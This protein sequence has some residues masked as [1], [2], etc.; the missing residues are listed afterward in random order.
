MLNVH[1]LELFYYVARAGGITASLRQIP[2]GIQQPA[3]SLQMSQ[4]EDAVGTQLFRR[5]PF[6]LTP[7]GREIYEFVTP[8]F[9]GLA[10]LA[11]R[12]QGQATQHLRLAASGAVMRE[13]FP[14]LLRELVRRIPGLRLS[15]RDTGPSGAARL[16]R[17][18]E[19]DLALG[20]HDAKQAAGLR[21]ELLAKLPM[22]L[23]V[24][25][26]S[27]FTNASRVL[28]EAATGNVP[29]ISSPAPDDLLSRFQAELKKR[30]I[31]WDVR[32]EA[33]ALDLVEAYVA[34]GFGVGLSLMIPG[35]ALAANIRVLKLAGFPIV[36]YGA[37]WNERLSSPA[38]HCLE[39]MRTRAKALEAG[40]YE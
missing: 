35:R 6:S 21:F 39:L 3:V 15:L 13:H 23:L 32:L 7:A 10:H 38:L 11:T 9:S 20:I 22:V 37:Y 19:V 17:A 24:E 18:H 5:R 29:L 4:L 8:F 14:W 40:K 27:P 31:R 28:K 16:L 33:P 30:E 1:H 34:Q 25:A 26:S 12:V 36:Q 2:Y